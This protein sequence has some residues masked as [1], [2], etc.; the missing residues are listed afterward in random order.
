EWKQTIY[1]DVISSINS[2]RDKYFDT[3]YGASSDMNFASN[4]FFDSMKSAITSGDSL[5][6]VSTGNGALSGDM[7][8]LISQ[9]ASN[10]KLSSE[11]KMS[12]DQ[13]INGKAMDFAAIQKS[14]D[15]GEA[16]NFDITLDGVSKNISIDATNFTKNADGKLQIDA[17]SVGAAMQKEVKQAFGGYVKVD[18]KTNPDT[19]ESKFSFSVNISD[20]QGGVEQG[21]ELQITGMGSGAFGIE[22]GS[23]SLVSPNTKLGDL[24]GA[25]GEKFAFEINGEKFKFTSN[26]TISSMMKTINESKAGV[27]MTYSSMT[28]SFSMESTATGKQ[29]GIEMSQSAGNILS[30]AFGDKVVDEANSVSSESLNTAMVDSGTTGLAGDYATK[31]ASLKMNVNGKDYTFE[32][33]SDEDVPKAEVERLYNIWLKKNF[34]AEGDLANIS[35]KDGKLQTA[36]GYAVKFEKTTVDMNDP[37]AVEEATKKDLAFAMGFSKNAATN[38]VTADTNIADVLQL[39]DMNF[40]KADGTAAT[41][42]SE[43]AKYTDGTGAGAKT[44]DVSFKGDHLDLTGGNTGDIPIKFSDA[45]IKNLFGDNIKLGTGAQDATKVRAGTDAELTINGVKTTRSSNTFTLDNITV[46]ATKVSD[47][48]TVIG[49]TRDADKIVNGVKSFVE[50]YN[51]MIK[52]LYDYTST[53]AEYR[54]YKPLTADQK[55]EMSEKEVE[56]WEKKAKTGLIRNDSIVNGFLSQMRTAMYATPKGSSIALYSIGIETTKWEKTGKLEVNEADLRNAIA[57]DPDAIRNLFTN[58]EDGLAK[59]LMEVSDGVA[60]LSAGN[61]GTLVTKAGADNWMTHEKDNDIYDQISSIKNN[62]SFLQNK[63][64]RERSRYWNQ[65]SQMEKILSNYNSQSNMISQQFS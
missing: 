6:I 7:K 58:K 4:A 36:A 16:I 43:I 3:S 57:T 45:G 35:Y 26:D 64:E 24:T 59:T 18:L 54:K 1:R 23:T 20:G 30:L 60:K 28:D 32:I 9:L 31:E 5:K 46:T 41:K 2:F 42:L 53:E 50:D 19:K 61:P 34:G 47:K 38:T 52:K 29:F 27:K 10:A 11:T 15:A 12:G 65:F 33:A 40:T 13:S 14:L 22:P 62:L 21:H 17:D 44:Y 48:E 63:Y 51:K 8:I 25:Q 56:E 37:K 55:K 39:K 49:T